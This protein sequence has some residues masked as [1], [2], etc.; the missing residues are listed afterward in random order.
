LSRFTLGSTSPPEAISANSQQSAVRQDT[1]EVRTLNIALQL[2][3]VLPDD[4]RVD[5][6]ALGCDLGVG[7]GGERDITVDWSLVHDLLA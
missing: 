7:S 4:L 3:D 5:D 6:V 2:A 1:E